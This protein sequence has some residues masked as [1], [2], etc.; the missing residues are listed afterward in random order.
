MLSPLSINMKNEYDQEK[1]NAV[2]MDVDITFTGKWFRK[3]IYTSRITRVM[4]KL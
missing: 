3:M 4:Y 1:N 2:R